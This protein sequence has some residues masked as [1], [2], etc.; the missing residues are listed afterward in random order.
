MHA[1]LRVRPGGG[2]QA[3]KRTRQACI[4]LGNQRLIALRDYLYGAGLPEIQ[5]RTFPKKATFA[6]PGEGS[7]GGNIVIEFKYKT[8]DGK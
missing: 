7:D 1:Q 5:P 2:K 3:I 4:D 6:E 8:K